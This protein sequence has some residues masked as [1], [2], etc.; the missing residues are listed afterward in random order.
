M[1]YKNLNE[2]QTEIKDKLLQH[3]STVITR[4]SEVT[5]FNYEKVLIETFEN[6]E[7][8]YKYIIKHDWHREF[9]N[10]GIF[11][12]YSDQGQDEALERV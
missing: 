6:K 8:G 10:K 12:G 5:E 1:D 4:T 11:G 3:L 2:A 9:N 7:L